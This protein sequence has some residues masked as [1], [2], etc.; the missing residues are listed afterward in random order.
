VVASGIA[1]I[2]G[3]LAVLPDA[4]RRWARWLLL[5]TLAVVYPANIRMALHPKDFPT[6]PALWLWVRLPFQ[7]LFGWITWRGT[8]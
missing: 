2:A 5:S 3:G 8:R 4:T 1:E 7:F 6:L